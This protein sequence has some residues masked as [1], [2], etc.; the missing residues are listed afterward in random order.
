MTP[1]VSSLCVTVN[2][3]CKK[4]KTKQKTKQNPML[5]VAAS[6]AEHR[7]QLPGESG[8]VLTVAVER[9]E[10]YFAAVLHNDLVV[11]LHFMSP[12]SSVTVASCTTTVA[13]ARPPSARCPTDL[14][15]RCLCKCG[16]TTWSG[17]T[18]QPA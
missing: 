14:C 18:T 11:G 13:A 5:N 7:Q 10:R 9:M 2:C 6:S 8:S 12:A 15:R 4:Q 3:V 1:R 17:L 16:N